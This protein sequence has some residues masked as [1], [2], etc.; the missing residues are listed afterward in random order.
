MLQVVTASTG[1]ANVPIQSILQM[2]L[3]YFQRTI[4]IVSNS[5]YVGLAARPLQISLNVIQTI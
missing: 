1:N 2:A 5:K 4:L 3:F